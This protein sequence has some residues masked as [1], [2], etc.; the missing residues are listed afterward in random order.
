MSNTPPKK[1]NKS[2]FKREIKFSIGAL[3]LAISYMLAAAYL[4]WEVYWYNKVGWVFVQWHAHLAPYGFIML[5]LLTWSYVKGRLGNKT[6][7]AFSITGT[8]FLVESALLLA[9]PNLEIFRNL[10]CAPANYY[11]VWFN[12]N[13]HQVRK[14]EFTLFR[15]TN[16]LGFPDSEW[17]IQKTTRK[18]IL[19]IGDSFTEGDGAVKDSCY[20]TLLGNI[21]N[22]YSDTATWEVMNAGVCGSDPV[23]GYMNLQD[24]LLKYRPDIVFQTFSQ[25]DIADDFRIRGGFER[26]QT[27][28]TLRYKPLPW[29]F[30]PASF[31]HIAVR[32]LSV[33]RISNPSI[34]NCSPA[35]L[36]EAETI[37]KDF[38]TRYDS[39]AGANHL[40]IV[41]VLLPMR[42][43]TKSGKYQ[44]D[45][46]YFRSLVA[47]SKNLKM[48]DLLP[49]YQDKIKQSGKNPAAYYWVKDGH[50]NADGYKMMAEC[51]A[52]Y[53]Q[54][55]Q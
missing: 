37:Q 9:K 19:A 49:C 50:H 43:E 22:A 4:W 52:A 10:I 31:S 44:Y 47:A 36:R 24:R 2:F 25:N 21:L 17:P 32:V 55:Q 6:L 26:F 54:Q 1:G 7:L 46:S 29:W 5:L 42:H 20:P 28:N 45:F 3:L 48:Y 14:S 18:R 11:H 38:V 23:F 40:T 16:T 33:L 27:D 35:F 15:Y 41:M 12:G 51:I 34:G 53:V 8:L 39:L 13:S 30:Y